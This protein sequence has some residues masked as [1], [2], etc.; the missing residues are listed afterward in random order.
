[1]NYINLPKC[2]SNIHIFKKILLPKN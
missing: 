2:L 1:M